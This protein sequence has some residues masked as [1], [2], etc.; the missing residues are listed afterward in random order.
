ME[1]S[2]IKILLRNFAIEVAIYTLLVVVYF[3]LVLRLLGKPLETLFKDDI[4]LYAFVALILI[5]AQGVLL[6]W[7]TSFLINRLG[8][9]RL[10]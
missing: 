6:D 4:V 10:E 9:D 8:L 5:V 7:V 2:D 3:F 1:T